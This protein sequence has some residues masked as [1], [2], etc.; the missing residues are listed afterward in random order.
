[1]WQHIQKLENE[2]EGVLGKQKEINRKID[3]LLTSFNETKKVYEDLDSKR[4]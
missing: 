1:M 4:A 2:N 3:T